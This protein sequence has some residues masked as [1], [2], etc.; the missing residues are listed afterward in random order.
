[1]TN[2]YQDKRLVS[3]SGANQTVELDNIPNGYQLL[4]RHM[5]ATIYT[6]NPGDYTTA[7]FIWLGYEQNGVKF[8]LAGHDVQTESGENP[9]FVVVR[10]VWIPERATPFAYV[11]ASS[12]SEIIELVVNGDLEKK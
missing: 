9:A 3:A 4:A 8:Y 5:A 6:T 12:T 1:M 11:E 7:I 2:A 10:D